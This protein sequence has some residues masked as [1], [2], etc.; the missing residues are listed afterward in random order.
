MKLPNGDKAIISD[1]KLV[2]YLLNVDHPIQS[3]HAVLFRDLLGITSDRP[4]RLRSAI[5]TAP[6]NADARPGLPSPHGRKYEI[7]FSMTG[8][9][10]EHTILSAWII[11][12]GDMNPRLITAYIE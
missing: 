10:G 11:E 9:R 12:H 2:G 7:R 6:L 3:G 8:P 5:V 4:E 1:D